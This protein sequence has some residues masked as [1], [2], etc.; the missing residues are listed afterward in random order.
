MF[1]RNA[2]RKSL[3]RWLDLLEIPYKEPVQV[4]GDNPDVWEDAYQ[5]N[6][7]SDKYRCRNQSHDADVACKPLRT[8]CRWLLAEPDRPVKP[9]DRSERL[10]CLLLNKLGTTA[11][12]LSGALNG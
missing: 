11:E 10:S 3:G 7:P 9:L 5:D 12:E 6:M 8:F 1:S 2:G 4:H